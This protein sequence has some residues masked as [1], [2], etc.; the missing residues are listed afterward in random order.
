MGDQPSKHKQE[1]DGKNNKN[2]KGN[3]VNV[4]VQISPATQNPYSNVSD[5]DYQ[6]KQFGIPNRSIHPDTSSVQNT[7]PSL[8][9]QNR[10]INPIPLSAQNARPPMGPPFQ[11]SYSNVPDDLQSSSPHPS[12]IPFNKTSSEPLQYVYFD[13]SQQ[14]ENNVS[15]KQLYTAL[16]SYE[17]RSGDEITIHEGDTLEILNTDDDNWW[18]AKHTVTH[19]EGYIPASYIAVLD[20]LNS[21]PWYFGNIKRSDAIRFL[22][23]D[24]NETGS[25][26]VRDSLTKNMTSQSTPYSLSVRFGTALKSYRIG[27]RGNHWFVTIKSDIM[28]NSVQDLINY[29][30]HNQGLCCYLGKP[31]VNPEKPSTTGLSHSDEWELDHSAVELKKKIGSGQFGD[32]YEGITSNTRVA[33][34]TL[35]PGTMKP[36]NFLAEATLMKK[37]QHK[38]LIQLYA[39]CTRKEPIYVITEFMV[40]GDLL[41]Y[42]RNG[43]GQH[44]QENILIGMSAQIATGMSFLEEKNF[45]HRD[46]AARNILV[47]E[48]NI[49]KVA[50]FGLARLI[51]DDEY[52]PQAGGKFPVKWT[53]P[54]AIT[55]SRF[56]I[57]SDVW[58][59][60]ILLH[61]IITKGKIPYPGTTNIEL[62]ELLPSGYRMPKDQACPQNL[63]ELMIECWNAEPQ[64]RPTFHTL[65]W[66]LDDFYTNENLPGYQTEEQFSQMEQSSPSHI[67]N[68]SE[69][70]PNPAF[71][72]ETQLS[73]DVETET[74]IG[75]L[76]QH[77]IA[78]SHNSPHN[79][80][81]NTI[82][83]SEET[84][85]YIQENVS[86]PEPR[87]KSAIS[88]RLAMFENR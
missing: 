61:E 25:F 3:N 66:A 38:N 17:K 4:T 50:D 48:N 68:N 60:G 84:K 88:D 73:G 45:I 21:M 59:F 79:R 41:K 35:K 40:N 2:S 53:A 5:G 37:L 39:V 14:E 16:F 81:Q 46:L 52:T 8:G 42:L 69:V 18:L 23:L 64:K 24:T 67:N 20:S 33:I 78:E 47:D 83:A 74:Q 80:N 65:T 29:Y 6:N 22:M 26:L 49:V 15:N 13:N 75:Q 63:Y 85:H 87:K 55:H 76:E 12:Q 56:T 1:N 44:L 43:E 70:E 36:E 72:F 62:I 51:E 19:K 77:L 54:E 82:N 7:G 10:S 27:K 32:V 11:N 58:S 57:K 30:R 34:K 28:L 71:P 9:L 86:K 31:C